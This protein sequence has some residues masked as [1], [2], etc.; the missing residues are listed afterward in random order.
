[1]RDAGADIFMLI[2]FVGMVVMLIANIP[3]ERRKGKVI[4][5]PV[6]ID[7][8]MSKCIKCKHEQPIYLFYHRDTI[9]T[10]TQ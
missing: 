4:K 8:I 6:L 9:K 10:K 2:L 1:M 3:E 7:S 5:P